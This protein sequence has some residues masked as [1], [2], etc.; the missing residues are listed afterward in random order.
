MLGARHRKDICFARKHEPLVTWCIPANWAKS[1]TVGAFAQTK[2]FQRRIQISRSRIHHRTSVSKP[3][4]NKSQSLRKHFAIEEL[5]LVTAKA[6]WLESWTWKPRSRIQIAT[7]FRTG[8][9]R[10]LQRCAFHQEQALDGI[11]ISVFIARKLRW[12]WWW[13][14]HWPYSEC[15]GGAGERCVADDCNSGFGSGQA[16]HE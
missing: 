15:D 8:G 1:R 9:R 7:S 11:R 12:H 14:Q 2:T 3:K 16:D 10:R 5:G 4:W 13:I 6:I